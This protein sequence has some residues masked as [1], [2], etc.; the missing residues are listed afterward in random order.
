MG[1][2]QS[3]NAKQDVSDDDDKKKPSKKLR[4]SSRASFDIALNDT[5]LPK[6]LIEVGYELHEKLGEGAFAK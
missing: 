3:N 6:P 4:K 2:G 1:G 5:D